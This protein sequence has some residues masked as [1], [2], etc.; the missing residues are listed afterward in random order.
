[1]FEF[2]KCL[3][4]TEKGAVGLQPTDTVKF[5][6]MSLEEL[7]NVEVSVLST[8]KENI[9]KTPSTV[10]VIDHAYFRFF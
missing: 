9:F 10:S 5:E 4:E 8:Q 3:S 7:M 6:S 2:C 1:M